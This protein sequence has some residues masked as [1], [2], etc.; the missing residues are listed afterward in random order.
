MHGPILPKNPEI[1]KWI[2][3]NTIN[4]DTIQKTKLNS[5]D[6]TIAT[7]AREQLINRLNKNL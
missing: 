1:T 2:I 5:L 3:G 6:I 7:K 4:L